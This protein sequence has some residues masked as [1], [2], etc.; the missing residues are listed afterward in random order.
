MGGSAGDR[1]LGLSY[2]SPQELAPAAGA[3]KHRPPT[4]NQAG[5]QQGG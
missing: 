4:T 1:S 2:A 3:A 5:Q